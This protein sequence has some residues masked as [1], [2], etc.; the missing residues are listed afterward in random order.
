MTHWDMD[1]FKWK[2]VQCRYI[3]ASPRRARIVVVTKD[4]VWWGF[5]HVTRATAEDAHRLECS[6]IIRIKEK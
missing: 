3:L 4:K 6:Y 2:E 1:H 5:K